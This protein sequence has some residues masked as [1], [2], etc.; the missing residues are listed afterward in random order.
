MLDRLAAGEAIILARKSW[1]AYVAPAVL[2]G[3][4]LFIAMLVA[5]NSRLLAGLAAAHDR[6]TAEMIVE[7]ARPVA[8]A[9]AVLCICSFIL[10]IFWL[11]SHKL[12]MD[13]SGVWMFRGI[14]PWERREAPGIVWGELGHAS[15]SRGLAEWALKSHTFFLVHRFT[16]RVERSFT[17]IHA[18][19]E[20]ASIVNE[21]NRRILSG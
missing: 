6:S 13:R 16:N 9:I 1:T 21:V 11:S 10:R 20:V 12:F 5:E 4:G 18:G 8:L 14:V 17:H 3:V 7:Y 19:D 2:L 15:T